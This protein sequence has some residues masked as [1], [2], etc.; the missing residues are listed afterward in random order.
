MNFLASSTDMSPAMASKRSAPTSAKFFFML[1]LLFMDVFK[2]GPGFLVA[3]GGTLAPLRPALPTSSLLL[4]VVLSI[5]TVGF[6]GI[7]NFAWGVS[8]T[9][10]RG[11][12]KLCG[13]MS[14]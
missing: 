14:V 9:L 3:L 7:V 1:F 5:P 2:L 13:Y 11:W 10:R 8:S 6:K 4:P 12:R